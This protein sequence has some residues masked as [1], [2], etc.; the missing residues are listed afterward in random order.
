M[1]KTS[2]AEIIKGYGYKSDGFHPFYRT[3]NSDY[4]SKAPNQYT[5]PNWYVINCCVFFSR[6]VFEFNRPFFCVCSYFAR[7]YEFSTALAR[8][9]MYRNHSLN[10]VMDKSHI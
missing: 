7:K 6:N 1:Q 10:T 5:A 2:I 9:G 3:T 8:G 4:G